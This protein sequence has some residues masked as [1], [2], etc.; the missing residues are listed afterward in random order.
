ME[1]EHNS[2]AS[3]VETGTLNVFVSDFYLTSLL[4]QQLKLPPPVDPDA[5]EIR[6][7]K[8][9]PREVSVFYAHT[10]GTAKMHLTVSRTPTDAA[11]PAEVPQ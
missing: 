3:I 5:C 9:R 8:E 4:A 6:V 2:E 11:Q 10:K 1:S 7:D